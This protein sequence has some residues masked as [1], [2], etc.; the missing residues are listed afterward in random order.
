MT[1]RLELFYDYVSPYSYLANSRL[2]ELSARTGAEVVYR[3]VLLG[4]VFKATGNATPISVP[5][6]GR[7]SLADLQ[8]W[9]SRYS[10]P[11]VFNPAFPIST[12]GLLRGALVTLEEG[13]F[14]AYHEAIFTA[15]W[16]DALNLADETVLRDLLEKAGLDAAHIVARTRDEAI[17]EQL[18]ANT[19]EAFNRGAF[20]VP[21]FFVGEEMFFGNDRLEF[22]EAALGRP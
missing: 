18:R 20:G 13:S 1:R 15:M 21:T 8:R 16:R 10:I 2:G 19:D 11:F 7:Y 17:K 4:A 22:V 5:A 6:K 3:P 12:V 9:A 14:P